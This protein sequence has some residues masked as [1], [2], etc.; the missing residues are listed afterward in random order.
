M[1]TRVARGPYTPRLCL[2]LLTLLCG[3]LPPLA[4]AQ[5]RDWAAT[6][7]SGAQPWW[8]CCSAS[9][10]LT[11]T[12]AADANGNS[13]V[14]GGI[15]NATNTDILTVKYDVNGNRQW[16]VAY[17][18]GDTDGAFAVAVDGAGNAYVAGTLYRMTLQ[19]DVQPHALLLKYDP[20]GTLLWERVYQE[21]VWSR[22]MALA[23]DAAGHSYFAVHNY[24]EEDDLT[25]AQLLKISPDGALLGYDAHSFGFDYNE[26][27]PEAV[28][29]DA[30]G[31][32]YMA[33][34]L[35][36]PFE[37]DQTDYF[38]LQYGGWAARYDSGGQDSAHGV[39]VD[40][41]GRV[42]VIGNRGTAAF[43]STGA[44]LWSAPF[45]G[46]TRAVVAGD[47]G[48][49]VTGTD[50][51]TQDYRTTRYD[52]AT[53]APSWSRTSGG[54]GSDV[55]Y[56]LRAVGGVL[57]V[58]GTSS[59]GADNDALT[60]G[61]DAA[62]GAEIWQDR[63]DNGGDER[64]FAM[65]AA[66]SG[67]WIGGTEGPGNPLAIRYE[68]ATGPAV[69]ALTL[70][71]ATFPGGCQSSS[72]QITLSAPAPA[73]GTVVTLASTNPVAV[74]PASVTVPAGQTRATFPITAPAVSSLQTGTVS[75]TAG[76]QSRSATLR[77]RPIGV[78]S[79]VLGTNPVTGPNPVAGSVLLE[80]AAAPGPITVQL[81][82]SNTAVARPNVSS[83]VIPAGAATGRFTVSTADVDGPR[84]ATLKAATGGTSKT[85]VLEVR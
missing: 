41:S 39:A 22:G 5:V 8:E 49:W 70:S 21:G 44:A 28:T 56:S 69:S 29:L 85:V 52:A 68:L 36:K 78:L 47:G 24:G 34:R 61:L 10:D 35:Y 84:Y 43:S 13:W 76:A 20:S 32:A 80:C 63:Y 33:G 12:V 74:M 9:A 27:V 14:I 66:G 51:Q 17:D 15:S 71:S 60:V 72:G 46:G 67:L 2:L 57:Y 16:A 6:Y 65:A 37:Q 55:A 81:S 38:V 75:A 58:T 73:G 83:I 31:N 4:G 26:T 23:V 59:N 11:R 7:D 1:A 3:L 25:W 45:S 19:F 40:G 50:P 54:P 82:S 30:A 53:G 77:V 42:F 48:V 62:T 18:G 64:G 79:L